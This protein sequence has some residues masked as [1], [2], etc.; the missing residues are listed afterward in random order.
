V[1][2]QNRQDPAQAL[3]VAVFQA[4]EEIIPLGYESPHF[5]VILSGQ[6]ALTQ[7]GKR[8][9]T[10]GEQDIFGLESLLLKKPSQYAARAVQKCRIAKYS[11]E[12]LD[13]LI[14]QSPR[15]VQ[16]VLSS[17][18]RQLTQTAF[19]LLEPA[20]LSLTPVRDRVCFFSDG[21]P[22]LGDGQ[23]GNHLYR[24][25]STG[26]GLQVTIDGRE[27][28]RISKPGEFFGASILPRNACVRSIGPNA[29]EKYGADE[30]D[31]IIR[32]YP[33]SAAKI[34]KTMVERLEAGS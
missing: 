31:I 29:V 32:D 22:V 23:S 4:G 34:M 6:V 33:D 13:Y 30:F 24:L 7:N 26:E 10:L 27:I 20:E 28:T 16:G 25:L 1:K 21:Q 9:R 12:I 18:L 3:E 14:R 17:I 8:L 5:L 2:E 19:N 15:M 11:P